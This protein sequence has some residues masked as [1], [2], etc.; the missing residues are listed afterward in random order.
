M[1]TF[2]SSLDQVLVNNA[3][4]AREPGTLLHGDPA[5]WRAM[6]DVNILGLCQVTREFVKVG[7]VGYKEGARVA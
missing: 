7:L 3:G 6:L 5:A 2:S 4:L 1:N